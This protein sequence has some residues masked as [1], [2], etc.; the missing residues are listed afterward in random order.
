VQD[1]FGVEQVV[2]SK[3]LDVSILDGMMEGTVVRDV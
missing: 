2:F 1:R 3:F